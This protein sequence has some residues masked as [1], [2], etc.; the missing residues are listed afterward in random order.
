VK[1]LSRGQTSLGMLGIDPFLPAA[2]MS[3][4]AAKFKF[5]DIG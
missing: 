1:P 3:S 4:G 5:S 2:K